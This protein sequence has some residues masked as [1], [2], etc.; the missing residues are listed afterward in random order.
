MEPFQ[1]QLSAL[2][3]L[4]YSN[5]TYY[6]WWQYYRDVETPTKLWFAYCAANMCLM[7]KVQKKCMSVK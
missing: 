2:H 5:Q 3:H 7:E 4:R 1:A 6:E